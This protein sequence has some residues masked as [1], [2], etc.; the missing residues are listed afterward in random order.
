[1]FS[2]E[3]CTYLNGRCELEPPFTRATLSYQVSGQPTG[4]TAAIAYGYRIAM[5][6]GRT[7]YQIVVYAVGF[8]EPHDQ[9]G[10]PVYVIISGDYTSVSCNPLCI[11]MCP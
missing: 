9:K 8:S 4:C 3:Q 1:M 5:C 11:P 10:K 7:T 6:Q 2:Q